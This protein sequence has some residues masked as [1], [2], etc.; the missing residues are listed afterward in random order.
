MAKIE[1]REIN[2][3][4]PEDAYGDG[5]F[6]QRPFLVHLDECFRSNGGSIPRLTFILDSCNITILSCL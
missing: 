2:Y 6:A 4:L 1:E 5:G 3:R